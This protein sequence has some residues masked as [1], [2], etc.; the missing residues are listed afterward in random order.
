MPSERA[1]SRVK[2]GQIVAAAPVSQTNIQKIVTRLRAR[3]EIA[4][5]T[6]MIASSASSDTT[7]I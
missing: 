6:V 7:T 4:E 1:T 5:R 3:P 2:L